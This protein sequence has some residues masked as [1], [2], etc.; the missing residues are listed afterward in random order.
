[1]CCDNATKMALSHQ[2]DAAVK[3][4]NVLLRCI[5]HDIFVERERNANSI[6]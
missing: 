5:K 4:S 3:E 6:L 1:M 2:Y